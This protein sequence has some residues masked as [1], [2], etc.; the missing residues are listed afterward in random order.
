MSQT[1][2][3]EGSRQLQREALVN[4]TGRVDLVTLDETGTGIMG[5]KTAEAKCHSCQVLHT[6]TSFQC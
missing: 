2:G 4:R 5:E 6:V 1:W 3:V